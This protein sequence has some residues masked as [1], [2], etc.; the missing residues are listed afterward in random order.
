MTYSIISKALVIGTLLVSAYASVSIA[1]QNLSEPN[2]VQ[3]HD[4][5]SVITVKQQREWEMKMLSWQQNIA[6][7]LQEDR[8]NPLLLNNNIDQQQDEGD[9][10]VELGGGP[11]RFVQN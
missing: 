9:F 11:D 6:E 3:A 5:T 7:R 2:T 4:D 8:D 1:D 10:R